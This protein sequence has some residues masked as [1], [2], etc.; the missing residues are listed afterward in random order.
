MI[1]LRR[2]ATPVEK[3]TFLSGGALFG[4][5]KVAVQSVM[6]G[7]AGAVL[8]IPG[9]VREYAGQRAKPNQPAPTAPEVRTES[10]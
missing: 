10:D 3:L 6:R 7:K 5:L 9:G 8:G 2:H 1:L 4:L